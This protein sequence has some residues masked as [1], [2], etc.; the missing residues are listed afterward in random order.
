MLEGLTRESFTPHLDT[1]FQVG[2]A[3]APLVVELVEVSERRISRHSESFSLVFRGPSDVF[4][5]Q[6]TYQFHHA[7]LGELALFIV[8]LRA[9]ER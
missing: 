1:P 8:P 5:P 6:A 3:A 2:P 7:A 9:K 4:L